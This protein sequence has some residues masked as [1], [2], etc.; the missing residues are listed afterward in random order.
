MCDEKQTADI[1][2]EAAGN[3]TNEKDEKFFKLYAK[4]LHK[5]DIM[6]M[7]TEVTEAGRLAYNDLCDASN[8]FGSD[9]AIESLNRFSEVFKNGQHRDFARRNDWLGDPSYRN[10]YMGKETEDQ[11]KEEKDL[12]LKLYSMSV[13]SAEFAA[14]LSKFIHFFT[15]EVLYYA[16]GLVAYSV[17]MSNSYKTED[18]EKIKNAFTE[19]YEILE[20]YKHDSVFKDMDVSKEY[21]FEDNYEQV[22]S[23]M[24]AA[25]AGSHHVCEFLLNTKQT[26]PFQTNR[27]HCIDRATS[28]LKEYSEKEYRFKK[29]YDQ[30]CELSGTQDKLY[31]AFSGELSDFLDIVSEILNKLEEFMQ[32]DI[33]LVKQFN[34]NT[35]EMPYAL[36]HYDPAVKKVASAQLFMSLGDPLEEGTTYNELA[37]NMLNRCRDLCKTVAKQAP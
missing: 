6:A 20:R 10:E 31:Q 22:L 14:E 1:N 34:E 23:H 2:T 3:T 5:S 9:K 13:K 29:A 32:K 37:L 30:A 24:D 21:S 4:R 17:R 27:L 28:S 35:S 26:S 8:G 7:V 18:V 15:N 12:L 36:F 33:D 19:Y 11:T 16:S 25:L